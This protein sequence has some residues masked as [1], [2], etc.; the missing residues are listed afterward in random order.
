M[1]R[2]YTRYGIE[3]R[4]TDGSVSTYGYN[5]N[6]YLDLYYLVIGLELQDIQSYLNDMKSNLKQINRDLLD[7]DGDAFHFMLS[8]D[9]EYATRVKIR[10]PYI[11]YNTVFVSL[12][13]LLEDTLVKFNKGTRFRLKEKHKSVGQNPKFA[14]YLSDLENILDV[15]IPVCLKE[16]LN[17]YRLIRNCIV[18][19][20]GR[21]KRSY[22]VAATK[23]KKNDILI[24]EN[25]KGILLGDRACEKF[26]ERV[27]GLF[28]LFC[29]GLINKEI[30]LDMHEG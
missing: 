8:N 25:E 18:H 1:S 7:R 17:N 19:Y 20:R 24:I 5:K 28:L 30:K 21:L 15:K 4:H 23:L 2:Y 22:K 14:D 12:Y 11:L 29:R 9:Y 16:E 13:S 3:V 26:I 27:E 10:Y 6:N